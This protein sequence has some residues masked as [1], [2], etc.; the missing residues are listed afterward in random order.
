MA[1]LSVLPMVLKKISQK[2]L[3]ECSFDQNA[4]EW[5]RK[6]KMACLDLFKVNQHL[7]D[8]GVDTKCASRKVAEP[9]K[10][11]EVGKTTTTALSASS[12][13]DEA[14]PESLRSETIEITNLPGRPLEYWG[15]NSIF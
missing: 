6:F 15:Y 11:I 3:E 9:V 10:I 2:Q 4:R 8:R 1:L 13:S 14:F 7:E 5:N 12:S